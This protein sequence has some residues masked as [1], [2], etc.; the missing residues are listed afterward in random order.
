MR[1]S[2]KAIFFS[3]IMCLFAAF[4]MHSNAS[5]VQNK[6]VIVM[7][8]H[9]T[10]IVNNADMLQPLDAAN[11][12][13]NKRASTT[14]AKRTKTIK[15]DPTPLSSGSES[16]NSPWLYGIGIIMII[17]SIVVLYTSKKRMDNLDNI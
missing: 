7:E 4:T 17:S 14:Q 16:D 13:P 10:F 6:Y 8:D 11:E 3:M 15:E 5:E 2:H 12:E 9:K 1:K